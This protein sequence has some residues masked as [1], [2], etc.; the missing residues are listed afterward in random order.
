MSLVV[1]RFCF[2]FLTRDFFFLALKL[3]VQQSVLLLSV[4]FIVQSST[5]GFSVNRRHVVKWRKQEEC[6][7]S[8]CNSP[9]GQQRAF[10]MTHRPFKSPVFTSM[11]RSVILTFKPVQFPL[12]TRWLRNSTPPDV[13]RWTLRRSS[14]L[15][16][17]AWRNH[18]MS[19]QEALGVKRLIRSVRRVSGT[20]TATASEIETPACRVR[21]GL[22]LWWEIRCRRVQ[23]R[24]HPLCL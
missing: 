10:R 9:Q 12:H 20:A 11:Q 4:F 18:I 17:E 22:R 6:F 1:F 8:N 7:H 14:R 23:A 2:R 24:S 19:N 13:L 5:K 16:I 15:L 3:V 21:S